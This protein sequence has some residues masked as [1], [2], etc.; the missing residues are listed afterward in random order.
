MIRQSDGVFYFEGDEEDVAL[1]WIWCCY[2][3]MSLWHRIIQAVWIIF[4]HP[5]RW[6]LDYRRNED[7]KI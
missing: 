3:E 2:L 6:L 1:E 4:K 5:P 7:G